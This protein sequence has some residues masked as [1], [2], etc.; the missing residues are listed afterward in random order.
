MITEESLASGT[1]PNGNT[2]QRAY[3]EFCQAFDIS[4]GDMMPPRESVLTDLRRQRDILYKSY[5]QYMGHVKTMTGQVGASTAAF[6]SQPLR[7]LFRAIK[8]R[9]RKAK[10]RKKLPIT[11]FLLKKF[12]AWIIYLLGLDGA[13]VDKVMLKSI[14]AILYT[15]V[16]G[17]FRSGELTKTA[18]HPKRFPRREDATCNDNGIKITLR[19]S[20][21]DPFR[22][23]VDVNVAANGNE[24][25]PHKIWQEAQDAAPDKRPDAPMFQNAQGKP[26]TYTMLNGMIKWLAAKCGL[27]PDDF[28]GHS[29]RIGGATTLALLG[30]PAHEIRTLGRWA[31]L[32][33]QTYIRLGPD[34][35]KRAS[36]AFGRAK[37]KPGTGF[38]GEMSVSQACTL[39][40]D[41]IGIVFK[42]R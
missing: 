26:I 12:L 41:N 34:L 38:Y 4:G 1:N 22:F 30:F 28:A 31:S 20:K 23:G 36:A 6:D 33:Y 40:L 3:F 16:F 11:S 25:C 9:A 32:S 18:A 15:G 7:H 14:A 19:E 35:S 27:D 21:T 17:L 5:K 8:K 2:G 29:L 10:R 13:G 42:S 37:P 24:D 39:S